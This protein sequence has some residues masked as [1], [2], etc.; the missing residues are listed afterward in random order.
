[1]S[2]TEQKT[3]EEHGQIQDISKKD[4]IVR[5]GESTELSDTDQKK[6]SEGQ[7]VSVHKTEDKKQDELETVA[8]GMGTSNT[9]IKPEFVRNM[10]E[11]ET[12][13]EDGQQKVDKEPVLEKDTSGNAE[14]DPQARLIANRE[15][16]LDGNDSN[17]IPEERQDRDIENKLHCAGESMGLLHTEQKKTIEGQEPMQDISAHNTDFANFKEEKK[18]DELKTVAEEKETP[19]PDME[20]GS[21]GNMRE[22]ETKGEDSQQKFGEEPVLE[23]GTSEKTLNY[24]QE[25]LLEGNDSDLIP[26]ERQDMDIENKSH[27][28]E[29]KGES[30]KIGESMG[31]SD[32]DQKKTTEGQGPMQIISVQN[33]DLASVKEGENQDEETVAEVKGTSNMDTKHGTLGYI[34][35]NQTKRELKDSKESGV[36]NNV[37]DEQDQRSCKEQSENRNGNDLSKNGI[38]LTDK[39]NNN[40]NG[41]EGR[42]TIRQSRENESTGKCSKARKD[43]E[44]QQKSDEDVKNEKPKSAKPEVRDF[45]LNK[46]TQYL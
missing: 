28:A 46:K 5:A 24:P 44:N 37:K 27:S 29:D 4:E 11:N 3:I 10:T 35:E 26:K 39:I 38:A 34:T 20:P 14:N 2:D 1:M 40:A 17:P 42:G 33:T 43:S 30:M 6:T 18:S 12:K 25:R 21:L 15:P 22:N 8:E 13:G 41:E 45:V 31:L 23:K 19:N 32:A 7:D 36:N 9:D 16:S